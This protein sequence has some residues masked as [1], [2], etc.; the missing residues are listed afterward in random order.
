MRKIILFVLFLILSCNAFAVDVKVRAN[1]AAGDQVDEAKA[2]NKDIKIKN[3]NTIT[4]K[5]HIRQ[6]ARI[7]YENIER[8]A[9][10]II[11]NITSMLNTFE[12]IKKEIEKRN[13]FIVLLLGGDKD[14]AKEILNKTKSINLQYYKLSRVMQKCNVCS[15]EFKEKV[16]KFIYNSTKK[17]IDLRRSAEKEIEKKGL[18]PWIFKK[19][20][21]FS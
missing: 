21:L 11:E 3:P 13:R 7:E 12:N 9:R 1:I 6:Q 14:N 5:G 20:R 8:Q 15:A 10:E 4:T 19:N 16:D 17:H 18:I 2:E